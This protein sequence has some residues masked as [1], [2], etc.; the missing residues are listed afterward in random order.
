[1]KSQ[2]PHFAEKSPRPSRTERF[3]PGRGFL[4]PTA[5]AKKI[6]PSVTKRG[7]SEDRDTRNQAKPS[8]PKKSSQK[9]LK[10]F[11]FTGCQEMGPFG[12]HESSP[13]FLTM[14]VP[15]DSLGCHAPGPRGGHGGHCDS[16][17]PGVQEGPLLSS[18]TMAPTLGLG[19]VTHLVTVLYF[20]PSE[21]PSHRHAPSQAHT[22][23]TCSL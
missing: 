21:V 10:Q 12:D 7:L 13:L 22:P 23:H 18:Q 19:K 11:T 14:S 20:H 1:M 6:R 17:Q 15:L 16:G 8:H 2:V 3:P 4:S 9:A 5:S